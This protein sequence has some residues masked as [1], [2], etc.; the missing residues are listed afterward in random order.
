VFTAGELTQA[1][2]EDNHEAVV[3]LALEAVPEPYRR[4]RRLLVMR[5]MA[6]R[7]MAS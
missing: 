7:T 1:T 2:G 4:A 3:G 5:I 6:Q